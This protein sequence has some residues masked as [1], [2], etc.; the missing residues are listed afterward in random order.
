MSPRR[1]K[2]KGTYRKPRPDIYTVMLA[3][4][5]AAIILGCVLLYLETKDYGDS[6]YQG[7]PSVSL[8]RP[9]GVMVATRSM[10]ERAGTPVAGEPY[11]STPVHG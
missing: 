10:P 5:L 11:R 9:H 3:I 1:S 2:A 7:V 4:S 6:P 8:D